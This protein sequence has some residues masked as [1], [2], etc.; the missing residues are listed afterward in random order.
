MGGNDSPTKL[1]ALTRRTIGLWMFT[2]GSAA[3]ADMSSFDGSFEELL[4]IL[5]PSIAHIRDP[6]NPAWEKISGASALVAPMP[7]IGACAIWQD[8]KKLEHHGTAW[9]GAPGVLITAWHVV[10]TLRQR[11]RATPRSEARIAFPGAAG[12]GIPMRLDLERATKFGGESSTGQALD[13]A[14][15]PFATP[16]STVA[17][18]PSS[19]AQTWP[20]VTVPGYP[21]MPR[22][23]TDELYN[24]DDLCADRRPARRVGAF[25]LYDADVAYGHSGAPVLLC[26]ETTTA[27]IAVHIGGRYLANKG[28]FID[29]RLHNFILR[30]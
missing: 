13:V 4:R 30:G 25:V 8:D 15:I 11:L 26:T 16:A 21:A 9:I 5:H 17:V 18:L 7:S 12:L 28:V 6:S 3:A 10:D 1:R 14:R 20:C 23:P 27:A 24:G 19:T 2:G 22:L 29:A